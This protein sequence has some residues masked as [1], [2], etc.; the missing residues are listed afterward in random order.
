MASSKFPVLV[1]LTS[2]P[3]L[4]KLLSTGPLIQIETLC[5][6]S[7]WTTLVRV[8]AVMRIKVVLTLSLNYLLTEAH[9]RRNLNPPFIALSALPPCEYRR[10]LI[11]LRTLITIGRHVPRVTPF[12]LTIL[13]PTIHCS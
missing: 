2:R 6:N 8:M 5:L 7:P 1:N 9:K 3:A 13:T 11:L 10:Y 12:N 4:L